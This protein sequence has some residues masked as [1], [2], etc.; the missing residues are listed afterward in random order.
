M[1][2]NFDNI[3]DEIISNIDGKTVK[4]T[5]YMGLDKIGGN[6][7][8]SFMSAEGEEF[9]D[10]GGVK[11]SVKAQRKRRDTRAKSKAEERTLNAKANLE[12]AK[13]MS[14][15]AESD[16]AIAAALASK[17]GLSKSNKATKGMSTGAKVGIAA[18]VILLIGSIIYYV[19]NREK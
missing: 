14:K 10:A 12:S 1:N 5:A 4:Y 8:E 15:G 16:K 7:N 2:T 17:S 19:K 6:V 9:Y 18:G 13:A 3:Q 11:R